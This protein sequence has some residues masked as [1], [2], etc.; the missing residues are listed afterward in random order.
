MLVPAHVEE[1]DEAHAA[2]DQPA[3]QQ[4]VAGVGARLANVGAVQ[5]Q[6]VLG[7]VR[8]IGQLGHGRLHAKGQLVLGDARLN[9][10]VADAGET[11]L[12]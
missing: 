4:A 7:L 10:G 9:F 8:D 11:A 3:G 2:L 5:I 6:N 1:L 12:R